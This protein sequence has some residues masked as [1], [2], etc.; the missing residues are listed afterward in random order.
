MQNIPTYMNNL[1]SANITVAR[2]VAVLMLPLAPCVSRH[3]VSSP[4]SASSTLPAISISS[5][6]TPSRSFRLPFALQL[7]RGCSAI[8]S[9]RVGCGKSTLLNIIAGECDIGARATCAVA[10]RTL[11]VRC[12]LPPLH[13]CNILRRYRRS[14]TCSGAASGTTSVSAQ[15]ATKQS[16][17]A[18]CGLHALQR[19]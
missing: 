8:V 6:T 1:F 15:C 4:S 16:C 19:T 12:P 10:G 7:P 14:L 2:V 13:F 9:G 3:P 11:L 17:S 18:L 5:C